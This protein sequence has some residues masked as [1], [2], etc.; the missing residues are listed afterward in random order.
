[1]NA[2]VLFLRWF[3]L[4]HMR[5]PLIHNGQLPLRARTRSESAI[6]IV[7]AFN[8][9]SQ[10]ARIKKRRRRTG[11]IRRSNL[12]SMPNV[13]TR[14]APRCLIRG[15]QLPREEPTAARISAGN[16]ESARASRILLNNNVREK[17]AVTRINL[18]VLRI[19]LLANY[20]CN[21]DIACG[22]TSWPVLNPD[23]YCGRRNPRN[24]EA[25]PT[26][27]ETCCRIYN[28]Q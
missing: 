25:S 14:L 20:V 27:R 3:T 21:V 19:E 2:L 13:E 10:F 17:T 15:C 22:F 23:L 1:M 5:S 11:E 8:G 7:A 6:A 4:L 26:T 24:A 28:L 12:F 9:H 18:P 16:E